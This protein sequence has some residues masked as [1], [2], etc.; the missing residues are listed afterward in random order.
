MI[1]LLILAFPFA[2]L[3]E[4]LKL[5][6]YDRPPSPGRFFF[7]PYSSIPPTEKTPYGAFQA[8]TDTF[9]WRLFIC[10]ALSGFLSGFYFAL[11]FYHSAIKSPFTGLLEAWQEYGGNIPAI[12]AGEWT[13]KVSGS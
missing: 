7:C 12:A 13:G 8:V 5:T 2:V 10:E 4:I 11:M 3:A 6:K 9:P 1:L